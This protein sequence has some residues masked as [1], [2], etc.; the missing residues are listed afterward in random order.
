MFSTYTLIARTITYEY[1]LLGIT[2][3]NSNPKHM[4]RGAHKPKQKTRRSKRK[5]DS[6]RGPDAFLK[7][8]EKDKKRSVKKK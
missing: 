4:A 5:S 3:S 2:I 6:A 1:L 7:R 8:A